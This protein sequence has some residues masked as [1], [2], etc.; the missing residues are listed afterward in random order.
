MKLAVPGILAART[1]IVPLS[2]GARRFRTGGG[3]EGRR[4][5][6]PVAFALSGFLPARLPAAGIR[7]VL[8]RVPSCRELR[9]DRPGAHRVS[10]GDGGETIPLPIPDHPADHVPGSPDDARRG[11]GDPPVLPPVLHPAALRPAEHAGPADLAARG[12]LAALRDPVAAGF[13]RRRP[14]RA[15]SGRVPGRNEP[16][17]IPPADAFPARPHRGH[18]RRDVFLPPGRER[19]PAP[20]DLLPRRRA[21][22]P[23]RPVLL[24]F[25]K[26]VRPDRTVWR[27]PPGW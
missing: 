1:A 16:R 18:G 15:G 3:A 14:G 6:V 11:P 24:V 23:A 20:R 12:L 13:R 2:E 25:R 9:G 4:V 17:A 19:F 8:P 27:P 7:P 22:V 10:V 21:A 26:P 5:R